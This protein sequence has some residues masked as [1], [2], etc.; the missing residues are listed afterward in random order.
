MRRLL[1]RLIVFAS[2]LGVV[3]ALNVGVAFAHEVPGGATAPVGSNISDSGF[4]NG[5]GN[6]N[7]NAFVAI[8]RNP[9]CPLHA[10]TH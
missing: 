8:A 5:F 6:P 3:M 7:S 9:R 4:E 10:A 1:R 2:V